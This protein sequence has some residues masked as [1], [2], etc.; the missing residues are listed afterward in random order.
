[1]GMVSVSLSVPALT[2]ATAPVPLR[3]QLSSPVLETIRL[4]FPTTGDVVGARLKNGNALLAPEG[5]SPDQWI[6]ADGKMVEWYEG[7]RLRDGVPTLTLEAYNT[8]ATIAY[9]VRAVIETSNIGL[10]ETLDLILST[11]ETRLPVVVVEP[12]AGVK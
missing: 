1:M 2:P 8:H 11:L 12:E 6:I 5:D 4:F 10:R 3:I 9:T 7:T